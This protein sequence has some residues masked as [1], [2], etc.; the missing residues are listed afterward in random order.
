[1]KCPKEPNQRKKPIN[2]SIV[3]ISTLFDISNGSK[4][5][6]CMTWM[7]KGKESKLTSCGATVMTV[8]RSAGSDEIIVGGKHSLLSNCFCFRARAFEISEA[9]RLHDLERNSIG[10]L[11]VCG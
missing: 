4:L 5:S 2:R 6:K 8:A 10:S 1:M 9:E 3:H 7:Y 11:G